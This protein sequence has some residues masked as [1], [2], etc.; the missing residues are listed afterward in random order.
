M[1]LWPW[2]MC[3]QSTPRSQSALTSQWAVGG[4]LRTRIPVGCPWSPR[5]VG[6][7]PHLWGEWGRVWDSAQ[8]GGSA[9][10]EPVPSPF[11]TLVREIRQHAHPRRGP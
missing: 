3:H 7:A 5:Q 2:P 1:T 6:P 11:H 8:G 4:L 10:P 9:P